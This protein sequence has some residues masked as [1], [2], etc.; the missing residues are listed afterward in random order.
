MQF[1]NAYIPYGAY[2][3]TPFC[4]WQGSLAGSHPILLAAEVGK[5]VLEEKGIA[6]ECVDALCLG[7]TIPSLHGFYGAPWLAGLMGMPQA[8]GTTISQA[9]ATSVRSLVHAAEEIS[10][11]AA[12]VFLAV[13]ADR[14]SNGPHLYYPNPAGP[15]GTGKAENWVMDNFTFDPHARGSMI[16]TAENVASESGISREEQDAVSQLRFEQYQNACAD[17]ASFHRRYMRLPLEIKGSR[18]RIVASIEKDEGVFPTTAE[19]LAKLKPVL[20]GGSVTF[21]SQTHPADGNAG[22]ILTS[23][24]MVDEIGSD[25]A[26]RIRLVSYGQ[27]RVKKGFMPMANVP[28]SKSALSRAGI[29]IGDVKVVNTHNPFAVNDIFFAREMGLSN[30]ALNRYGSSL[31]WGHPQA[32]TGVRAIIEMI[33][34]LVLLGGGFGLFTGCAAGDS[35]AAVVVEV[36]G[37]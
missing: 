3:S 10:H 20:E 25:D 9:C 28:A 31:V 1:E 34:E 16:Q 15:G 12:K 7:T 17:D 2:W 32:P 26:V 36:S 6:G 37:K 5:E 19:G 14:T 13:T 24:E 22:M 33:E 27:A 29:G 8:T 21:G 35:A 11:D 30:D 23:E 18:G 4:K